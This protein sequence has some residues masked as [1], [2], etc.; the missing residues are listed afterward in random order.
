MRALIDP[1]ECAT[2]A[3]VG[4]RARQVR[5]IYHDIGQAVDDSGHVLGESKATEKIQHQRADSMKSS[6]DEEYNV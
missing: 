6:C 4:N 3:A 5:T 2:N 1:I